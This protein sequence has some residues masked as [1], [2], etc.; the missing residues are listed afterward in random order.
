[1]S[2]RG[3][4]PDSLGDLVGRQPKHVAFRLNLRFEG[5]STPNMVNGTCRAHPRQLTSCVEHT[6]GS[7]MHVSGTPKTSSTRVGHTQDS[8]LRG[9][10]AASARCLSAPPVSVV[11]FRK[12]VWVW[13]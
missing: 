4:E 10:S 7:Y 3:R 11:G 9:W 13:I 1:M 2:E 8:Q 12:I 6:Q 5:L